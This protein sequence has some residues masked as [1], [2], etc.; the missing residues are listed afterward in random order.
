MPK[1]TRTTSTDR[2]KSRLPGL[3]QLAALGR[4]PAV[5][6]RPELEPRAAGRQPVPTSQV[7]RRRAPARRRAP[8]RW[9]TPRGPAAGSG[10]AG[11]GAAA[12]GSRASRRTAAARCSRRARPSAAGRSRRTRASG[13]RRRGRAGRRSASGAGGRPASSAVLRASTPAL[14]DHRPGDRAQGE[15]EQQD[16]GRPHRGQLA[17]G[18]AQELPARSARPARR[19]WSRSPLGCQVAGLLRRLGPSGAVAV[20]HRGPHTATVDSSTR[21]IC[22]QETAMSH[23]PVTQGQPDQHQHQRRRAGS[24]TAGDGG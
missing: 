8:R 13:R 23:Q 22:S 19:W 7:P 14:R 15:Q 4:D 1:P 6:R 5:V 18:P 17:P 9:C 10:C 21:W 16:Q 24:P 12:G 2:W 11:R 20:A 3:A